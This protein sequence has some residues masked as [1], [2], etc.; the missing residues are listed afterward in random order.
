MLGL[1]LRLRPEPAMP[2]DPDGD[3]PPPQAS[4]HTPSGAPLQAP[5]GADATNLPADASVWAAARRSYV[6]DGCASGV[7]AERHGLNAR[8]VRH[9]AQMEDWSGL[10]A[11]HR[12]AARR[13]EGASEPDDPAE[14]FLA[15]TR[16]ARRLELLVSPRAAGS[17]T[18]AALHMQ[19]A[20]ARGAVQEA[21]HWRRLL[22]ELARDAEVIDRALNAGADA[23]DRARLAYYR[24]LFC[25]V[26]EA[27]KEP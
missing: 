15:E 17:Q 6:E 7:V 16:A 18:H 9:H 26:H 14:A 19:E 20:L 13:L 5:P 23:V 4:L 8:T 1:P 21:R 11:A 22:S 10:R 27:G 12:V 25:E 24:Q 2:F 3:R